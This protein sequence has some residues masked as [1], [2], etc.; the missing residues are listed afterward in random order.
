MNNQMTSLKRS[1]GFENQQ[2]FSNEAFYRD[3]LTRFLR[4][5]A[6]YLEL[7]G[8]AIEGNLIPCKAR[9]H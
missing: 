7:D 1:A 6:R 5:S 3:I 2:G 8:I 4:Q 9:T